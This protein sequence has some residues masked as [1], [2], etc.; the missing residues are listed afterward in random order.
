MTKQEAKQRIQKL[1][2][3]INRYRYQYHVLDRS[4]ISDS[5]HDSLKH[6]LSQLE[7]QF[8]ELITTD[9]PTQRV[10]GEV[11]PAFKKVQH[12]VRM[13]S[14]NDAFSFEEIEEWI[15]RAGRQLGKPASYEFFAEVKADGLAVS[16]EY[17]DGMFVRGST[18][19]DGTIGEDVTENL[20][21][22]GAIPLAFEAH[23]VVSF[24]GG[25]V[26][27]A[28]EAVS[29]AQSGHCE[30]RGEV[31]MK[32]K[33]FD[34]LN[35]RQKKNSQKI[36][37]NPR[38]VAAGSIRQLDP[39]IAASRN[40]SFIAWD[41]V[42][43][44]GQATHAEA[45]AI[46]RSLGF[47]VA[48]MNTYCDSI[49]KLKAYYR[50][51]DTKRESLD[52]NID[53]IV[54]IFNDI[55]T[56]KKLG[57]IG[58]APRGAV[59]WKFSAE[60]ATTNVQDIVVQVGRTGA[61]TPVAILDPVL[62]AGSTVSRATLHNEDEISR[63]D[64]RIGD[65]VIIQKA[66][67]VIPDVVEVLER[68]RTGSEKKF[69]M[70]KKCPVCGYETK[71]AAG[72]V[73]HYCTNKECPARH[74]ENLY[75][76][77]SKKAFNIDGLGPKILDQ[78]LDAGL[79]RDSADIFSL[80]QEQLQELER[81]DV[82][83]AQ[84]VAAAIDAAREID[85]GRF[86]YS[87]GI[88]HVGEETAQALA[89]HFG[90]LDAIVHSNEEALEKIS[91]VGGV[92]TKSIVAYFK[93]EQNQRIIEKMIKNGVSIKTIKLISKKLAGKTFVLTGTLD[94]ITRDQAKQK[95]RLLGGD[96]SS[97]V[98]KETDYVVAGEAA[99]SKLDKAEKLG[100]TIIDEEEF[101]RIIR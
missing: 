32:K 58:K 85:L 66:G 43:S 26:V 39:K 100:I 49:E 98:S 28:T 61:L 38:N 50:S 40:L 83:S 17:E 96:V 42:T 12:D 35:R 80:K 9:S 78:L 21:T 88:R 6:E 91:D 14:L 72:E 24:E 55:K 77:V 5:A 68:L 71:R 34:S 37:A 1:K 62:V 95:I 51:I 97:S 2:E 3:E 8:P 82:K 23:K 46:A 11:A 79:I 25:S 87:L 86:I 101:L 99:G 48:R 41:I 22:I 76:F 93:E 33:D 73:A 74:R 18:R 69:T 47:P 60:Q 36:F 29:V 84:N 10:G 53:G 16:L 56:F 65:T 54:L 19:G 70:P 67:D 7:E 75:H 31:Y 59:A 94:S 52:F 30:I 64:I 44:V 27:R 90:S 57:A 63:L 4:E 20:K 81:F 13:L 89:L 45:H 15:N 92:V